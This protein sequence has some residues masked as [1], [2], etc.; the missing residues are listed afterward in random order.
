MKASGMGIRGLAASAAK[1][2]LGVGVAFSLAGHALAAE[3][4]VGQ[5]TDG[6][7]GMQ[8][9]ASIM[10]AESIKFHNYLLMPIITAI[11]LFVLGLL[12]WIVLRYNK[13]ANPVPAKWSHNTPIEIVWTV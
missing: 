11:S 3:L 12:I 8:P 5:P 13:R 7:I 10:R 4:K 6:A 9:A 1:W 2:A